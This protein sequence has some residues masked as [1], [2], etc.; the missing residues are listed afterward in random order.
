MARPALP[1]LSALRAFEAA[2]RSKNF[3]QA[4]AQLGLTQAAVSYQIKVLEERVGHPL[5]HRKA[6]GVE[7]TQ[8]GTA[9]AEQASDA[10]DIIASAFSEAKGTAR[11]T[12]EL[13][14][15]PTFATSFLAQRLGQFQV[16]NPGLA[17]CLEVSEALVDFG[18]SSVDAA[19]RSGHGD[20]PDLICHKLVETRFTP[21]VSPALAQSIGGISSP[22]DLLR[23]PIIAGTD[24][25]W[26]T[27]L[28]AAG[29]EG[30]PDM[31]GPGQHL[32][33]QVL[34]AAA[35]IACQGVAMLTPSLFRDALA[36][37]QLIQ[38]FDLE[39]DDGSAYWLVY[40]HT[41]RNAPKIKTF[42]TWLDETLSEITDRDI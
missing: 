10:F 34:E 11:G 7:L 28:T 36:T 41:F 33:P 8:V 16:L 31:P 24:P 39:Y 18:A 27:W 40:P 42:Q 20:W 23:L 5:F 25:R 3:T 2:A 12:L 14:V 38:P 35:A 19:I 30:V 17:V 26:Q 6:R 21:M 22:E 1:P 13:S 4:A 15:I 32:G 9:L 29:F 37:G